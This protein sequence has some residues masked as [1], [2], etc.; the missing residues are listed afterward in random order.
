MTRIWH[1]NQHSLKNVLTLQRV[2]ASFGLSM[3]NTDGG[4]RVRKSFVCNDRDE[5]RNHDETPK[6]VGFSAEV[7][8]VSDTPRAAA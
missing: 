8:T 2:T 6:R 5:C 7:D 4:Q 3:P 1:R